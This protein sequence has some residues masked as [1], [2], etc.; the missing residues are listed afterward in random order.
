[1]GMVGRGDKK[2]EALQAEHHVQKPRD[3]EEHAKSEDLQLV[4]CG[5]HVIGRRQE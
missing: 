5:L 3:R 2:G 1:M 4:Q